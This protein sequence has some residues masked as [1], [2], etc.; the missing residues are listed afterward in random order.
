MALR[1]ACR[2]RVK[3]CLLR[4]QAW[5]RMSIGAR[6]FRRKLAATLAVQ[7][8]WRQYRARQVYN[9][10]YA[11]A[12]WIAKM[13]NQRHWG[14]VGMVVLPNKYIRQYLKCVMLVT[15]WCVVDW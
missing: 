7:C 3:K 6:A 10:K 5:V 2:D 9:L 8:W 14:Q 12:Q 1:F 13:L 11:E 15:C 4:L